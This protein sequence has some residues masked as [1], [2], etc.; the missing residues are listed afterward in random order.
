[1]RPSSGLDVAPTRQ[2]VPELIEAQAGPAERIRG[3]LREHRARSDRSDSSYTTTNFT[4]TLLR[5]AR[6]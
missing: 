1:M 5:V 4:S 3:L 2:A 6:E